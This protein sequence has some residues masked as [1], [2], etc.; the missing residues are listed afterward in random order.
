MSDRR[1]AGGRWPPAEIMR[2][3]VLVKEA[4]P[5]PF[6]D[7]EVAARHLALTPHTLECYRSVGGGPAFYKFGRHVRYALRDL[8]AC[9]AA[10]RVS[11][12]GATDRGD[13]DDEVRAL[14]GARCVPSTD[15]PAALL[16]TYPQHVRG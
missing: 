16:R 2:R 3:A 10:H 13:T 9:A 4:G 14:P 8:D 7:T 11:E 6:V 5:I 15:R 1:N 12:A